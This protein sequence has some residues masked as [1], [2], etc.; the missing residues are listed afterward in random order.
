MAA[1]GATLA[2]APSLGGVF[3][4]DDLID[5]AG[6]PSAE[7]ATFLERLPVTNRPLLKASYA[8]QDLIHGPWAP[9]F[10]GVNIALH[11]ASAALAA[12]LI[13]RAA[14][15]AGLARERAA[16]FALGVA[17]VWAAHP[18]LSETVAYVSGRSM[19]LSSLLVLGALWCA[20]GPQTALMRAAGFLCAALAPLARETAL[21]VP[22]LIVWWQMTVQPKERMREAALRLAPVLAGALLAAAAIAA[23][24]R[25]GDLI[26]H[27]LSQRPPLLALRNNIQAIPD[28]LSF[29][30]MPWRVTIAP[31]TPLFW[32]WA[33][34]QTILKAGAMA[35][36]CLVAV[37]LR[38]RTPL[39]AFG[40]GLA[41]LAL[42]PAN[43]ILW[44]NDPVALKPL[45]LAGLGLTLAAAALVAPLGRSVSRAAFAGALVL[46]LTL[47]AAS[48]SRSLLFSDEVALWA[49][50]AA[51][52]PEN[53]EALI[54][55]G[56]A[57]FNAGRWA[58]AAEALDRGLALAP[59]DRQAQ[60]AYDAAK[61]FADAPR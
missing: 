48:A 35:L 58:E 61:A 13:L 52:T 24:P 53:P 11:A 41:G 21:I 49:D 46:A 31:E 57:L 33:S 27:S 17:L 30:V 4:Y 51:K 1:F 47:G 42:L 15:L 10:H 59:W 5:V 14:A 45:Y 43:S 60:I 2:F 44:R 28:I 26:A 20:T 54:N 8:L 23:M 22:A 38:Q 39:F 36:A 3:V 12:A 19:G 9:G 34:W 7:A 6:N 18:A 55:L 16:P 37:F 40:L 56:Y 50:A 25:H 29:W 32:P